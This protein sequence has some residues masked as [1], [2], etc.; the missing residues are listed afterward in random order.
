MLSDRPPLL[1]RRQRLAACLLLAAIPLPAEADRIASAWN[2]AAA[3]CPGVKAA[4]VPIGDRTACLR[5]A[6]D[7]IDQLIEEHRS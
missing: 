5:L 1:D 7:L 3:V 2:S 4:E 6:R